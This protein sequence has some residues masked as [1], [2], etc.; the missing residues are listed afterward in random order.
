MGIRANGQGQWI[1]DF[2]Q[3][4]H[5]F[6]PQDRIPRPLKEPAGIL[7]D[8]PGGRKGR[9]YPPVKTSRTVIWIEI[10]S[11]AQV[12]FPRGYGS[13]GL[14]EEIRAVPGFSEGYGR[15]AIKKRHNAEQTYHL[16]P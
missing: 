13:E 16:N 12:L 7:P 11:N 5:L 15:N 6:Q 4:S 10:L 1:H 8:L 2:T 3:I 9:F 14:F